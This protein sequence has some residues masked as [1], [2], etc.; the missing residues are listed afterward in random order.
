[1][2]QAVNNGLQFEL[3][4]PRA[5]PTGASVGHDLAAC[6]IVAYFNGANSSVA[7]FSTLSAAWGQDGAKVSQHRQNAESRIQ[8]E[9]SAA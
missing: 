1:M 2:Y 6:I 4:Y 9:A 3:A 7:A 5:C 8:G